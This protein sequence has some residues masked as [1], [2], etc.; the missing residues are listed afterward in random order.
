MK[1]KA[2]DIVSWNSVNGVLKGKVLK[3]VDFSFGQ[4]YYV[5]RPDG[6]IIVLTEDNI[7]DNE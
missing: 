4:G 6:M 5:E 1:Y 3:I 2:G 7:I